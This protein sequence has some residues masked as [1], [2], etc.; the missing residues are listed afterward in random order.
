MTIPL[1]IAL[2]L[3]AMHFVADFLLQSHWMATN[4]SKNWDALGYHVF[5]YS[6]VMCMTCDLRFVYFNLV[7]HWVTDAITSRITSR[8]FGKQWHWFFV[9]VGL[10]QL[11]H[12]TC[13]LSIW[14]WLNP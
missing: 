12:M 10:D 1:H 8:L 6:A 5:T 2:L 3:A 7:L 11:I 9:V 13:L 4:K 14:V